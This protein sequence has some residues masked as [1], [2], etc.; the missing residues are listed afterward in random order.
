MNINSLSQNK[1]AFWWVNHKQTFSQEINGNYIWSPLAKANGGRNQFYDNMRRVR[2]GDIVFS[3]AFGKIQA[4]GMCVVPVVL[5][6]K[7]NEFGTV[8]DA[9][10][11]EGWRVGV[12]F[13]KLAI[14]LDPKLYMEVIGPV[15][16]EKYSPIRSDGKG[17][18]GAYLAEI[19]K[20]MA[21]VILSLLGRDQSQFKFISDEQVA[22]QASAI[23]K[24]EDALVDGIKNRT[25][26]DETEKEQ[27][28]KARRGQ[29]KFRQNLMYFERQCRITGLGDFKHLRAS[30]IK[31]W[32]ASTNFERLDGNNGF[33]LSPHV[34]HLFDL[35]Y[36]SFKDS[37]QLMISR[38]L[39]VSTLRLWGIDP[40]KTMDSV[41]A[42]QLPYL[43]FHRDSIFRH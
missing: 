43:E 25:D 32:R 1:P 22:N 27:L 28:I 11:D 17:N 24:A 41:R 37:G 39:E 20:P 33:L 40:N 31:P 13:D 18:Q 36:I 7:P 15:L 34:D 3:F 8:G 42:E 19:P 14:P 12:E 21:D 30:H 38:E 29:G 6:P 5:F 2:Q 23:Q 9:W 35:G 10:N 16:P 26:L 4:I